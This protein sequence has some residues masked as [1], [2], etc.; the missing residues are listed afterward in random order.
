MTFRSAVDRRGQGG[1]RAHVTAGGVLEVLDTERE[2]RRQ[3]V[4]AAVTVRM[5]RGR[6][7]ARRRAQ[8]A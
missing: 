4:S 6:F 3:V 5:L 8:R 2:V 1:L 7:L